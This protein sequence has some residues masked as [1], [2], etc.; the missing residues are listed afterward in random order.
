MLGHHVYVVYILSFLEEKLWILGGKGNLFALVV[1]TLY[2]INPLE[3]LT[4]SILLES[5]IEIE[6]GLYIHVDALAHE[7]I[8][9][10]WYCE[11]CLRGK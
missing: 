1:V 10:I 7:W 9:N 2:N 4:R 6:R 8:Q 3:A 5:C 11:V